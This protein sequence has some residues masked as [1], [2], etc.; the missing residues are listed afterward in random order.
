M[1]DNFHAIERL[2]VATAGKIIIAA[3]SLLAAAAYCEWF[4]VTKIPAAHWGDAIVVWGLGIGVNFAFLAVSSLVIMALGCSGIPN[5]YFA[6]WRFEREGRIYRWTGIQLLV[7]LFRLTGYEGLMRKDIPVRYDLEALRSYADSTRG[8]DA[9]HTL[10]G[11]CTAVFAIA[12]ELSYPLLGTM[13]IWFGNVL[14]NIYPIMLQR[15][16][17]PRVERIIRRFGRN[18]K[19][20]SIEP[21]ESRGAAE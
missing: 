9:T 8:A 17:R 15:Y 10:S 13:G 5:W 20:N 6:P 16:N 4:W 11:I 3:A 7:A 14:V 2:P 21:S 19:S 18:S 12:M 1:N